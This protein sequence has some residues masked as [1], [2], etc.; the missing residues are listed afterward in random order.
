MHVRTKGRKI[1]SKEWTVVVEKN[2]VYNEN[3][4]HKQAETLLALAD[5]IPIPYHTIPSIPYHPIQNKLKRVP[6]SA[7][8]RDTMRVRFG[9]VVQGGL[10]NGCYKDHCSTIHS[11]A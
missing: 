3:R 5:P 8:H 7:A 2:E 10:R 9:G 11:Y 1:G 6:L 4:W